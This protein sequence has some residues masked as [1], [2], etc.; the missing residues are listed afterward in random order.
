MKVAIINYEGVV[1]SSVSGPYDI[2]SKAGTIAEVFALRSKVKFEIDIV[3]SSVYGKYPTGAIKGNRRVDNKVIYDLVIVPAM[4]FEE[5]E[6]VL[7]REQKLTSWI[8]WQ[9]SEGSE[10]ASICMGAFLLAATGILNGKRATTHWMGVPLF[11]KMFPSVILEDS[12]VIID[13]GSIYSC[14][15]AFSF[16]TLMIYFI[17][18]FCGRD[19]AL[20]ASKVFMIQLHDSSQDAF[21]IFSLQRDHDDKDIIK[22]QDFIEKKFDKPIQVSAL[23][24]RFNMSNRT[25]IR[26]FTSATGNTPIEYIQRVRVEAAKRF[27]EKG[28]IGVEQICLRSGYEDFNFFRKVF[29]RYTG[30]S[31][32]EYRRKYGQMLNDIVVGA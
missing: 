32:Q 9:F 30:L 15:A 29:K 6:P 12:K 17:E 25:L 7:T 27:L 24:D 31:P 28:K 11:K 3:D 19:L 20:V 4:T 5:I 26:R 13:E 22:V 10:V 18:K 16:T 23:A 8:K 21:A 14:G 2:L 1:S